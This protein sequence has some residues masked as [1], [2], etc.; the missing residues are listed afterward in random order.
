MSEESKSIEQRNSEEKN[1][2]I[3]GEKKEDVEVKVMSINL[4]DELVPE[5][6]F[7]CEQLYK[8]ATKFFKGNYNK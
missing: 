1:E 6:G 5:W 4:E 3:N 2:I 7:N 8:I